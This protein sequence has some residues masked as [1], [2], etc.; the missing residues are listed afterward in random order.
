MHR[1]HAARE[2]SVMGDS[3]KGKSKNYSQ[4]KRLKSLV[5]R[6]ELAIVT[7]VVLLILFTLSSIYC[8]SINSAQV[9]A[10][11]ALNQYRLGSKA[12]T[13]AVQSYAVSG[14]T[15]FYDDYM[16]ELNVDKNRDKALET[17]HKIDIQDS[18][19]ELINQIAELSNGLVPLEE[20]A[21]ED[22]AAGDLEGAV[23]S[24]FSSE[25]ENTIVTINDTTE[26][27][28]STV[29]DRYNSKQ[30]KACFFQYMLEV[31]FIISL[32]F[33]MVSFIKIVRFAG[34]ELI[35]PIKLVSAQM[36]TL[37]Q[38]EFDSEMTLEPDNSE[39]GRM[40]GAIAFMKENMRSM[41]SE[42]SDVL[43]EMGD[44]NFNVELKQE[45]VGKFSEIK[46]SINEIQSQMRSA[47][48]TISDV[49]NKIDSGAVQLANAAEE[50][51]T[52][53]T[54]QTG[55]VTNLV[56]LFDGLTIN[57]QQN[58]DESNK[59]VQ[60]ADHAV[61]TLEDAN[62]KMQELKN[63]IEEI[64]KCSEQISTIIGDIDDIA[65]QTNLLALNAAIEAARAGEAGKGF[66][67]VADQ[68]KTLAQESSQAAGRTT[69][70]IETTVETVE[71]GT[72]IANATEANM[73]EVTAGVRG[74]AE[75]MKEITE[76]LV[77]DAS[78]INE[79][80]EN[81]GHVSSVVENNSATSEE[82]SAISQEQRNQVDAMVQLMN[83][84]RLN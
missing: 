33:I 67:V 62:Q 8:Q 38:G 79:V 77:R 81:L 59:T 10:V 49:S 18:E 65:S 1:F 30:T 46:D 31:L 43:K 73:T 44:G 3:A 75:K 84:F 56:G 36:E 25:Y 40:I 76:M 16:N 69:K 15:K 53:C 72:L 52:G 63:A 78:S 37:A 2:D 74:A 48:L 27:L 82:T 57:M 42:I 12:L 20:A 11:L 71:K 60:M 55:E 41:V 26:T 54:E 47:L 61:A 50:L 34:Y 17:L 32:G 14:D 21:M 5:I 45:Y 66:A 4:E 13:Y 6:G 58:V 39:V 35:R 23:D 28:A 64:N 70:L 7:G 19:W 83:N 51:A 80:K 24:V 22:V 29:V 68:V 9:N